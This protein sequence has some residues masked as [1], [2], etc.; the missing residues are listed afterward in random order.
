LAKADLAVAAGWP[1]DAVRAAHVAMTLV[2]DGLME[3]TEDG[4]YVLP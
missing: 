3:I 2:A 4:S 1:D